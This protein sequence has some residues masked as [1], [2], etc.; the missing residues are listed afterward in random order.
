[1]ST[2]A[3]AREGYRVGDLSIDVG[4]Q[5]VAGPLGA[6]ALPRLSFDLLLALVRRAP[7][8]VSNDEL[9]AT[10]WA[11]LVVSPETVTKRVNLLR[12]ALGDDASNPRYIAGLRSR[13]YRIMVPVE[14]ISA[15]TADAVPTSVAAASPPV[16]D[17]AA[18]SA[19]AMRP[20]WWSPGGLSPN[21]MQTIRRRWPV[22]RWPPT[23]P[24]RC[25]GS[26]TSVPTRPTRTLRPA[27]LR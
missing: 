21:A 7:D 17:V 4:Q 2:G 24:W 22:R 10:V 25:S 14:H 15:E 9:A 1:M 18:R 11:G 6:I 12:E 26:A 13:G 3:R 23:A 27:C 19:P 5:H 20:R 16:A 8:F